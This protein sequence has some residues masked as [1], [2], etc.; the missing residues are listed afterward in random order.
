ME[1]K[2]WTAHSKTVGIAAKLTY[3]PI[4]AH[5]DNISVLPATDIRI[6]PSAL[7]N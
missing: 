5:A 7:V 4:L 3:Y 6:F 2:F 1:Q